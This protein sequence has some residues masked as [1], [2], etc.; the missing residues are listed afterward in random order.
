[1]NAEPLATIIG[2]YTF[3]PI[4]GAIP[5]VLLMFSVANE[6]GLVE[7]IVGRTVPLKFTMPLDED[8]IALMSRKVCALVPENV[9]IPLL[10]RLPLFV[11][12]PSMIVV[13]V[14]TLKLP[15]TSRSPNKCN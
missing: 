9:V 7:F 8:I 13:V 4:L 14:P 12:S 11:R 15:V 2:P 1:M 5:A 6:G 10:V 3:Q